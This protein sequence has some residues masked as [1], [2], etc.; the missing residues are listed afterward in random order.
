[1]EDKALVKVGSRSNYSPEINRLRFLKR[2]QE[3]ITRLRLNL[4]LIKCRVLK[5]YNTRCHMAMLLLEG[6][7]RLV[8]LHMPIWI[9]NR[10][11]L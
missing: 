5:I 2:L 6:E 7:R 3:I 4:T 10:R 9:F 8:E 1:M 11:I